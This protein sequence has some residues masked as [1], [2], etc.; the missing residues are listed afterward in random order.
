MSLAN[1][2]VS[3]RISDLTTQHAMDKIKAFFGKRSSK[4]PKGVRLGTEAEHQEKQVQIASSIKPVQHGPRRDRT[5]GM[6]DVYL[7]Y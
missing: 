1:K 4:K 6:N 2:H 5:A 3:Q 7:Y